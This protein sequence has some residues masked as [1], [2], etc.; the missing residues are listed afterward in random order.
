MFS[1]VNIK[2]L[3][4]FIDAVETIFFCGYNKANFRINKVDDISFDSR[5]FYYSHPETQKH[6]W[7][8]S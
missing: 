3:L 1:C 5:S 8:K 6:F 4:I 2:K 7:W